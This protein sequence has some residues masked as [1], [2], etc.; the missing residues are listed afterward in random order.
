[1]ACLGI[2]LP[3]GGGGFLATH[4]AHKNI[5]NKSPNNLSTSLFELTLTLGVFVDFHRLFFHLVWGFGVTPGKC[6]RPAPAT[7][8]GYGSFGEATW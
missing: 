2:G 7:R 1:M 4:L 8:K 3:Q 5:R 6:F